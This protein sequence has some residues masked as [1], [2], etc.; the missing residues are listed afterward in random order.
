MCITYYDILC[1]ITKFLRTKN[2]SFI[3]TGFCVDLKLIYAEVNL[4]KTYSFS[5]YFV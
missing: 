2:D 5:G 1:V 3:F 4:E